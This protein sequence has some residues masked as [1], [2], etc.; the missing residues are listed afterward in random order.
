MPRSASALSWPWLDNFTDSFVGGAAMMAL[1]FLLFFLVL[2]A[3]RGMTWL[4]ARY[5]EA[6][7]V[8][9]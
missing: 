4:H 1:G 3:L 7:L 8:R 6:T 5:A 9:V 2:H